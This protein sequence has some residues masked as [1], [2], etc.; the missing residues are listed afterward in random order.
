QT[1]RRLARPA[2]CSS[3]RIWLHSWS[4]PIAEMARWTIDPR[5]AGNTHRAIH[6][7]FFPFGRATGAGFSENASGLAVNPRYVAFLFHPRDTALSARVLRCF[8]AASNES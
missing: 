2:H 8:L 3:W 6:G 4:S 7:Y 5:S 1:W